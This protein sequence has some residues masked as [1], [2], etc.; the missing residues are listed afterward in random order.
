[1]TLGEVVVSV[2]QFGARLGLELVPFNDAVVLGIDKVTAQLEAKDASD[3][4]ARQAL[5]RFRSLCGLVKR[6]EGLECRDDGAPQALVD[7]LAEFAHVAGKWR[8]KTAVKRAWS[9]RT[10]R[11]RFSQ[12]VNRLDAAIQDLTLSVG[13]DAALETRRLRED[14]SR[15]FDFKTSRRRDF[16][17]ESDD[18]NDARDEL[19][20]A[21]TALGGTKSGVAKLLKNQ[22]VSEAELADIMTQLVALRDAEEKEPAL[23]SLKNALS[24][25][26]LRDALLEMRESFELTAQDLEKAFGSSAK[27]DSDV[28]GRDAI[29][30]ACR[31]LR[32]GG[33]DFDAVAR[34][35]FA[36]VR[37]HAR[38]PV[39]RDIPIDDFAKAFEALF[40]PL[41]QSRGAALALRKKNIVSERA[42]ASFFRLW[43]KENEE[44]E[45]EEKPLVRWTSSDVATYVRGLDGNYAD[46]AAKIEQHGVDGAVLCE[47]EKIV[48]DIATEMRMTSVRSKVLHRKLSGLVASASSPQKQQLLDYSKKAAEFFS[49]AAAAAAA[50]GRGGLW[51]CETPEMLDAYL[52]KTHGVVGF[53]DAFPDIAARDLLRLGDVSRKDESWWARLDACLLDQG[54]EFYRIA[55]LSRASD[56]ASRLATLKW[57]RVLGKGSFGVAMLVE[58]D[59]M[60]VVVKFQALQSSSKR[61]LGVEAHRSYVA[62]AENDRMKAIA[63][64]F[65][66]RVFDYGTVPAAGVLWVIQEYMAGSDLRRRSERRARDPVRGDDAWRWVKDLIAGLDALH[67]RMILHCDIKMANVFLSSPVDAKARCK[68]GD[69]GLASRSTTTSGGGGGGGSQKNALSEQHKYQADVWSATCVAFELFTGA[70]PPPNGSFSFHDLAPL[71]TRREGYL[72]RAM[73]E[74]RPTARDLLATVVPEAEQVHTSRESFSNNTGVDV[75]SQTLT[76]KAIDILREKVRQIPF[77]ATALDSQSADVCKT[78][79]VQGMTKLGSDFVVAAYRHYFD[80]VVMNSARNPP[81]FW[82][83]IFR[84]LVG[85]QLRFSSTL[86]IVK[87]HASDA[88][89]RLFDFLFLFVEDDPDRAERASVPRVVAFVWLV[90][91]RLWRASHSFVNEKEATAADSLFRHDPEW[92]ARLEDANLGR[93]PVLEFSKEFFGPRALAAVLNV[94]DGGA[95]VSTFVDAL[96]S[97]VGHCALCVRNL[98][99]NLNSHFSRDYGLLLDAAFFEDF[100]G[101]PE[102]ISRFAWRSAARASPIQNSRLVVGFQTLV[103]AAND[104]GGGGCFIDDLKGKTYPLLDLSRF[105]SEY[106]KTR[107]IP[108]RRRGGNDDYFEDRRG[109]ALFHC[110]CVCVQLSDEIETIARRGVDAGDRVFEVLRQVKASVRRMSDLCLDSLFDLGHVFRT[111]DVNLEAFAWDVCAGYGRRIAFLALS[112]ALTAAFVEVLRAGAK[113]LRDDVVFDDRA[114][115]RL[116]RALRLMLPAAAGNATTFAD[117]VDILFEFVDRSGDGRGTS[118]SRDDDLAKLIEELVDIGLSAAGYAVELAVPVVASSFANLARVFLSEASSGGGGGGGDQEEGAL[119]DDL[120]SWITTIDDDNDD[121]KN[122]E[123]AAAAASLRAERLESADRARRYLRTALCRMLDSHDKRPRAFWR[124][125]GEPYSWGV[126]D[127]DAKILAFDDDFATFA[128]PTMVSFFER[129]VRY[130]FDILALDPEASVIQA[131]F[132]SVR[133]QSVEGSADEGTGDDRFGWAVDG[134]RGCLWHDARR[135]EWPVEWHVG[136]SV[137]LAYSPVAGTIS[138]AKNGHP[139]SRVFGSVPPGLFPSITASHATIKYDLYIPQLD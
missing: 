26:A 54:A 135:T 101:C 57:G 52:R 115:T 98:A 137:L 97:T 80:V 126:H 7:V 127:L 133:M 30:A 48:D 42:F 67:E 31:D 41:A 71:P 29:L 108:R 138:Y 69:L 74:D 63:S 58:A 66:V 50:A 10:Y 61:I 90:V 139:L 23:K 121:A 76:P 119:I 15:A 13:V 110:W 116:S 96:V 93:V 9:A 112:P 84:F 75:L 17:A 16:D 2:I 11:E 78:D 82:Q 65:V 36:Y 83:W 33:G 51:S 28:A 105:A 47:D 46:V 3:A 45:E 81:S 113:L 55:A 104:F 123:E 122:E 60:V 111:D 27:D 114:R 1:M 106:V 95:R 73:I 120:A 130:Q 125:R 102:M 117:C 94:D 129:E 34:Q 6:L 53:A 32:R 128:A 100:G 24:A 14:L 79:F 70:E 22:D 92:T 4:C 77:L 134:G 118:V 56:P 72:L 18:E 64:D 91:G 21:G 88:L 131:G 49:E 19:L 136:D 107:G 20:A 87:R 59:Q 103:R 86:A 132:A 43:I 35:T 25:D 62:N 39:G 12:L 99:A 40:L 85:A 38:V 5:P 37:R 124:K 89:R 44:E 109:R 68:L 8:G